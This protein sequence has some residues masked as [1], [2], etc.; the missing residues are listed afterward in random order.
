MRT[1]I[2]QDKKR[3]QYL[4]IKK[5]KVLLQKCP[6]LQSTRSCGWQHCA[7]ALAG[8]TISLSNTMTYFYTI[9]SGPFVI[10]PVVAPGWK[11]CWCLLGAVPFECQAAS[12]PY[13][14]YIK[15]L[16][17]RASHR[18]LLIWN[19]VLQPF[20]QLI[21]SGSGKQESNWTINLPM[22]G[23]HHRVAD[24]AECHCTPTE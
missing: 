15:S 22:A 5:I 8:V 7:P 21:P 9:S 1:Q 13:W 24:S 6:W 4:K 20:V 14:K 3:H 23:F 18:L 11:L 12:I 17:I 19:E 16:C 2:Q 10:S